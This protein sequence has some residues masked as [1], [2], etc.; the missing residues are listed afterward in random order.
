MNEILSKLNQKKPLNAEEMTRAMESLMTGKL[1]DNEVEQ[2]LLLLRE[3]GESVEE[4]VAAAH[5]MRKH[6]LKLSKHYPDLLDTCGTGGDAKNTVNV[7]T[8]SAIVAASAGALV[9][10]HGNRSV[11]SVCGSADLLEMLGMNIN[12]SNRAIEMSIE[13]VGFGFFFAP[14]FHPA[15]RF[16]MPARK[17]IQGK[18]IF[19]ILGPLSNPAGAGHQ[20]IGVYSEALVKT[21]AEALF[22][23]G[24]KKAMVVH[25]SDGLDE[26]TTCGETFVAEVDQTGVKTY[27]ISGEEF[28]FSRA[29]L[30]DLQSA[31]KTECKEAAKRTLEGE[32]GPPFDIVCLNAGAALYVAG[33]TK[34]FAE[35]VNLAKE[36]MQSGEALEKLEEIVAFSQREAGMP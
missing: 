13:T 1:A 35:G 36:L 32:A 33:R 7:S 26:I 21:M 19:N 27:F 3:K 28:G 15:I 24:T 11:S 9:G 22:K 18:T 17:K 34:A 30:R 14:L 16:A 5:V 8:L 25:G 6:S 23:L 2:F 12:L 29:K 4:I 10:K 20:L 31:S